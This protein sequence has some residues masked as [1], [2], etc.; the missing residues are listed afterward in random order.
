MLNI[1]TL[2]AKFVNANYIKKHRIFIL[3]ITKKINFKLINNFIEH[4]L[5]K[6]I[7]IKVRLSNYV[8]E[9]LCLIAL[10]KKFDVI[11]NMF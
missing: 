5:T 11:L 4:A 6:I 3:F 7:I 9:I 8:N 2:I 10:L 1:K